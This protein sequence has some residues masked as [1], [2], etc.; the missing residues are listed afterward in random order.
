MKSLNFNPK[1]AYV[2]AVVKKT[3]AK[4]KDKEMAAMFLAQLAHESGGFQYIE[5][6]AC[7]KPGSC[8]GKYG[9]GAPGK[10]YHG[11]GFIQLSWPDNYKKAG[12][13]LNM[14]DKLYSNPDQ[15]A[16]DPNLGADV[17]VWFWQ[18]NVETA[19]GVKDKKKF[20]LTTKAINGALECKGSNVDQ[21]KKRYAAYK[22][23]VKVMKISNPA[24]ESG[25]Y[26]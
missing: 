26:N 21:S 12:T 13:G 17:S 23:F 24:S 9:T 15:V 19:P 6:I 1:A 4:F 8:A 2:D 16:K 11:R 22:A 3:N 10:S 14:G 5:E 7:S 18:K 25:C 20:G